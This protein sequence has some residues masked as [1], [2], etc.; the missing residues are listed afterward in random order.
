MTPIEEIKQFNKSFNLCTNPLRV[1]NPN[2]KEMMQVSCGKCKGCMLQKSRHKSLLC[3][4]EKE[5]A[6][7]TYIVHLTYSDDYVPFA[8]LFVC[9]SDVYIYNYN[10]KLS[11]LEFSE[12]YYSEEFNNVDTLIEFKQRVAKFNYRMYREYVHHYSLITQQINDIQT[13]LNPNEI[14][15]IPRIDFED[16]KKYIKRVRFSFY[17]RYNKTVLQD[18]RYFVCGEYGPQTF[19]IH[20]HILLY[21]PT[22]PQEIQLQNIR[23]KWKLGDVKYE[24]VTSSAT[25][26][27]AGYVNSYACLPKIYLTSKLRPKDS[28][29]R[30]FGS[31][32]YAPFRKEI[33]ENPFKFFNEQTFTLNGKNIQL[34]P[35]PHFNDLYF[36]KCPRYSSL[37]K[38]KLYALYKLYYELMSEYGLCSV[39]EIVDLIITRYYERRSNF[40]DYLEHNNLYYFLLEKYHDDETLSKSFAYLN[41]KLHSTLFEFD[42]S[43]KDDCIEAYQKVFSNVAS[44]V[45]FSKHFFEFCCGNDAA[46]IHYRFT[47][48]INYYNRLELDKLNKHYALIEQL[49]SIDE[50]YLLLQYNNFHSPTFN[51]K[52]YHK[53]LRK[54]SLFK[55]LIQK[56]D[57]DYNKA[58]KHKEL[59]DK[60]GIFEKL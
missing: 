22:E 38:S 41:V 31:S 13:E 36:P 49:S 50:D 3:D 32:F 30:Y 44:Y 43:I 56:N 23:N 1:Y 16:V 14:I 60:N 33:Y 25:S 12:T 52:D 39:A 6:A 11:C 37:P 28:H 29:S 24:R 34:Q 8:I 46:L 51:I 7:A 55:Q 18:L 20:Y 19:R 10:Y 53:K 57:D 58:I 5:C 15:F 47:Q 27:V 40:F 35:N 59:N 26:Y 54:L 45:Y 21:F 48:I 9:G 4:Y 42:E 2:T 17:D